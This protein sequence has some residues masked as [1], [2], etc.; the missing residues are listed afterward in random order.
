MACRQFPAA[1]VLLHSICAV[2]STIFFKNQIPFLCWALCLHIIRILNI[3]LYFA[4]NLAHFL[5]NSNLR[6]PYPPPKNPELQTLEWG[7]LALTYN[8]IYISHQKNLCLL[9]FFTKFKFQEFLEE[10]VGI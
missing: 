7:F 6:T 3:F 5:P 2:F 1:L 9:F 10:G 4:E 8:F